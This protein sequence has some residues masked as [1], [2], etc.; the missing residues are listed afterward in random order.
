MPS[1]KRRI[2]PIKDLPKNR[3]LKADRHEKGCFFRVSNQ[4]FRTPHL[5]W[6]A[7]GLWG[8]LQSYPAHFQHTFANI[9]KHSKG[10]EEAIK[11]LLK[12]LE[13]HKLLIRQQVRIKTS[14]KIEWI[15]IVSE[16]P[17]ESNTFFVSPSPLAPSV[18]SPPMVAPPMVAPSMV[19]PSMEQGTLYYNSSKTYNNP[20]STIEPGSSPTPH[21]TEPGSSPSSFHT[22]TTTTSSSKIEL[23]T[24]T[25]EELALRQWASQHPYWK[26]IVQDDQRFRSALESSSARNLRVQYQEEVKKTSQ[27]EEL[28]QATN[29]KQQE[30]AERVLTHCPYCDE[31]HFL[32]FL[33]TTGRRSTA[34]CKHWKETV[35]RTR[36]R[37][38]RIISTKKGYSPPPEER[39]VVLSYEEAQ[40]L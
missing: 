7:K 29:R 39:D 40:K 33:D 18:E 3:I 11:T 20:S 26:D 36:A 1:S 23:K 17:V 9:L 2:L 30:E 12:E 10:K 28:I 27:L 31:Y 4:P 14:G 15:W 25:E 16:T 22:I 21:S 32:E 19:A 5:S 35:E 34:P 13:T 38:L 24:W 6:G 8:F 37:G